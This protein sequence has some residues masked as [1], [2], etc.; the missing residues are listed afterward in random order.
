MRAALNLS[1]EAL[2][3]LRHIAQQRGR[4]LGEVASEPILKALQPESTA[5]V[6]N[7][8]PVLP[9]QEGPAPDLRLVNR[10]RD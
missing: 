7:G 9:A 6:R 10:L 1:A 4:I 2:A 3:K 5:D 8:V